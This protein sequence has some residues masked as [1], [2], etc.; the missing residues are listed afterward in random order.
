MLSISFHTRH[1]LH[2]KYWS[3]IFSAS[4]RTCCVIFSDGVGVVLAGEFPGEVVSL[5]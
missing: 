4:R 2:V 5:G 1:I 3:L